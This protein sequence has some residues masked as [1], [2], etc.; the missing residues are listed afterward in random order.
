MEKEER[1]R[2]KYLYKIELYLI[3]VIP[4]IVAGLCLLNTV[5]S[6]IEI[7]VPAISYM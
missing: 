1:L 5:L 4:M 3:R 2:N 7:D 6:Y